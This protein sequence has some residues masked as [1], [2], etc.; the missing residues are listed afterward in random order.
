L[1]LELAAGAPADPVIR[2]ILADMCDR[3]FDVIT[4]DWADIA[5]EILG[6]LE[7]FVRQL[8][9]DSSI[10]EHFGTPAVPRVVPYPPY[11]A[12]IFDIRAILAEFS[13]VALA[14]KE[15]FL[16]FVEWAEVTFYE[17]ELGGAV[18]FYTRASL[19][20]ISALDDHL[21]LVPQHRAA[22]LQWT[23]SSAGVRFRVF[24]AWTALLHADALGKRNWLFARGQREILDISGGLEI[25]NM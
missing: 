4:P 25:P 6:G 13:E 5:P 8:P 3:L 22:L 20:R 14:D 21:R 17:T 9:P 1:I 19:L 15:A 2:G 18:D 12:E 23:L 10:P 24:D 11:L 16:R 7:P